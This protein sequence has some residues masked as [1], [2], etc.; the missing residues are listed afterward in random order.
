MADHAFDVVVVGGGAGGVAAAVRAAQLGAR[1][2][3]AEDKFLGGLCMNRGC[4][5]FVHM[6]SAS[7]ILE[8]LGLGKEMGIECPGLSRD[9][10]ALLKRQGELVAFMRQGVQGLFKKNRITLVKGR[11]RLGGTGRVEVNG[12]TFSAERIILATGAEWVRPDL[13]GADLAEVVNSDYLLT[14]Q[15]L[16]KRCILVGHGPMSIEIAQ[17]LQSYGTKTWLVTPERDLLP[18]ESKVV[19]SRLSKA[20]QKQG[21]TLLFQAEIRRL[22]PEKDGLQVTLQVKDREERLSADI[23]IA[24]RRQACLTGLGLESVGLDEKG[25]YL[26]VNEHME[27]G[28]EGLFAIG[29]LTAPEERH[30]S[31]LASSGGI[32]A[33]ENA[34]GLPSIL[35]SNTASRVLF[36][37]PQVACVGLTLKAAKEAGYDAVSGTAPLSMN[38]L[39]MILAQ[40]EGMVEVVAEKRYGEILGVHII[41]DG[42][43]EMA[44]MGVLAIQMEATLEELARAVFPH[45]TLSEF[46]AEAARDALGRPIYLP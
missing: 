21:I 2:A 41:G 37:Q 27:T 35:N 8:G 45:P 17:F 24:L 32:V 43:A 23:L 16:P 34:M 12:E 30:Y 5:P 9:F 19:R 42:A 4:V 3:V 31:H 7:R 38:P 20:L 28:V 39:G 36:T 15:R 44:G 46:L 29:D 14:A 18:S 13:P 40:N 11:G 33:A 6:M 1:V 10:T 25:E 22:K 26:P